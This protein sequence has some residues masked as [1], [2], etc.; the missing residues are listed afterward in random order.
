MQRVD[1]GFI[2]SASDL[3]ND[4]EC[5]R[6]TWLEHRV[7]VG[8]L[9]RPDADASTRLIAE[10]GE[11]HEARFHAEMRRVHGDRLVSFAGRVESTRAAMLAAD[12]ATREAM[13]SGASIISQGTFFDGTFLGRADF[14]RRIESPS[15][16]WPWSYEVID[17]KLA[18]SP[19]AYFVLQL[20]NYSEHLTRLQGSAPRRGHLVL[21][22][23]VEMSF[24]I[25]DYA[26]YYRRLKAAFLARAA[27]PPEA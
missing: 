21:G 2:Y 15:A 20:C 3:N 12:E 6:L 23:N 17:T 14:L 25:D 27:E 4:L 9:R 11:A 1:G 26:A 13:A 10:K 16:R 19:K 24:V 8:D 18:L 5:R 7:A 22:S